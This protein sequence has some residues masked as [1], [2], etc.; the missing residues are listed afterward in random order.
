MNVVDSVKFVPS[1]STLLQS[2]RFVWQVTIP[3]VVKVGAVVASIEQSAPIQ[4][5]LHWQIPKKDLWWEELKIEWL[6][7]FTIKDIE[8]KKNSK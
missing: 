2:S 6:H 1:M 7:C 8:C 4:P 5:S 3:V